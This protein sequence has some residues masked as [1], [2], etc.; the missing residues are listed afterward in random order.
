MTKIDSSTWIFTF[1][2]YSSIKVCTVI[3]FD[4]SLL[5]RG[6]EIRAPR[7]RPILLDVYNYPISVH[8]ITLSVLQCLENAVLYCNMKKC[9]F[10]KRKIEF[11]GVNI[12]RDGFEMEDKKIADVLDWQRPTSVWVCMNSSVL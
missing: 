7:F 2:Y 9:E 1:Y 3:C 4:S 5:I 8:I 10:N 11:I 12:S 6:A